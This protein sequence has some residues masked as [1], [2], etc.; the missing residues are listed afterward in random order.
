M[1]I[2]VYQNEKNL[3]KM[4]RFFYCRNWREFLIPFIYGLCSVLAYYG[5]KFGMVRA[6]TTSKMK[7]LIITENEVPEI[8]SN[9]LPEINMELEKLISLNNVYKTME[10]FAGFTKQLIYM[11]NLKEVKHCFDIAEKMLDEG[12]NLVKNAIENV[13][14]YSIGT[15]VALSGLKTKRLKRIFNGSLRKEYNRQVSTNG[16]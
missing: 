16:I 5:A 10:C 11:G 8:L 2:K 12:N 14:V 3:T 4:E 9:E 13:F 7:T 15:V 1:L 6:K